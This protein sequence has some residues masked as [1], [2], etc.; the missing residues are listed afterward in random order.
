MALIFAKNSGLNDDM[1][2]VTDANI[3]SWLLDFDTEKNKYDDTLNAVYNVAKSD[4]FG[5]KL[6]SVTEFGDFEIVPEGGKAVKDDIQEGYSKLIIHDQMLK[7]FEITAEMLEDN[8]VEDM[9]IKAEGFMRAYKRSRLAEASAL[10]TGATASTV[11][12]GGKKL[13]ATCADGQPLFSTSHTTIKGGYTQSNVFTNAFGT[14]DDM[15]FRLCNIGRNFKN[16]SGQPMGYDYDTIIIPS[17][18]PALER[19][20]LKIIGSDQQVGNG[21]NDINVSKGK[22]KL[23]VDPLW[24]KGNAAT[25]PYI[26]MSSQAN[27]EL[28]GNM[29]Y[30]RTPLTVK[31]WVDN[32]T[33]NLKFS[34]R[35]RA[36]AGFNAWEH[37]IL[38]G[39]AQGTTLS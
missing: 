2:K 3:R 13:D 28:R 9:K 31:D 1:W 15:L 20:I 32:D 6:G 14:S 24:S 27:K 25:D 18:A 29:F 16:A 5:E 17:D 7:G 21:N 11:N 4:Q 23:V 19:L 33:Y 36:G 34:G 26:I 35:Y 12:W 30:D 10:L 39:A 38:G 8:K 37:A 22:F